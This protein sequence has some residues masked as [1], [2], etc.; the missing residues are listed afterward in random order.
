MARRAPDP[1]QVASTDGGGFDRLF[2]HRLRLTIAVLLARNDR[3]S[4]AR[5]KDVTGETDGNLGANLRK[6]ED[7]GYVA[8]A[9]E[10][11]DRKPVS[12]Y[13]LNDA[14]R[15]ALKAHL[16]SLEALIAEANKPEP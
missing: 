16:A 10:F 5:L 13:S 2:E 11:A 15:V 6:L 1:K 14:G 8:V 4:F 3:L 9:K 7:A 12:W